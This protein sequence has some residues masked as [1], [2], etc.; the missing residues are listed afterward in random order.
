MDINLNK[1]IEK[2]NDQQKERKTRR[3]TFRQIFDVNKKI[4]HCT[5]F[6]ATNCNCGCTKKIVVYS[7]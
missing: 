2:L 7:I 5:K 1:F 3:Q 6:K 4:K